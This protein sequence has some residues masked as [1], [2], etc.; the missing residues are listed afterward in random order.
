MPQELPLRGG[1]SQEETS[2]E[3]AVTKTFS[4]LHQTTRRRGGT[5]QC[6]VLVNGRP[7]F[8]KVDSGAK[9]SI[10]LPLLG[11]PTIMAPGVCKLLDHVST[12]TE[13][14]GELYLDPSIFRGLWTLLEA[15]T[16]W[17]KPDATPF[18]LSVPRHL[19][20]PLHDVVKSELDKLEAEGVIRD[21]STPMD[22]C[23]GLV[24]WTGCRPQRL[25][26]LQA[27]CG[28]DPSEQSDSARML[29]V[30]YGGTMPWVAG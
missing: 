19:P 22:W 28:P 14:S 24:C 29:C 5:P 12:N 17:L 10:I 4:V 7:L 8:F 16:I 26:W 11:F 23:A 3:E 6:N 21:I 15:Y 13:P 9:V 20:D 2:R 30:A 25:R 1:L 18:S 27:V